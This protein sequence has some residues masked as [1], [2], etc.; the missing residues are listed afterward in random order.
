MTSSNF[1]LLL[2]LIFRGEP[3]RDVSERFSPNR[4][5]SRKSARFYRLALAF[6]FLLA[7]PFAAFSSD[8]DAAFEPNFANETVLEATDI[9]ETDTIAS[10]PTF[11]EIS[12]ANT[13]SSDENEFETIVVS[14]DSLE[15]ASPNGDANGSET[16]PN[17]VRFLQKLRPFKRAQTNRV[18]GARVFDFDAPEPPEVEKI[19]PP[20]LTKENPDLPPLD[21]DGRLDSNGQF[22]TRAELDALRDETKS[23]VWSKGDLRITPY[24]FLNLSVSSDTQRAVPG[25]FILYPQSADV[26]DSADFSVD[27]RT[28]RLGFK[29]DGPRVDALSADVRGC[30]EFDFQ[31]VANGS[32][33]KGGVQLRRAYVELVDA[34][35]ERRLLAGQDWEII[36]PLAPQMLNYLPAGYA[37]NLQYRRPQLRFEQ[38]A[39]FGPNLRFLG[40]IAICD[41]VLSDYASTTGVS[42]TSAAWPVIEARG[43]VALFKEA[44]GGLPITLGV[45]GHIGEQNYSFSP[46]AGTF[47]QTKERVAIKTWSTNFDVDVPLTKALRLQ[48]EYFIGSNLSTFCGGINQGVDLYRRDGIAA[49]GGW[50]ALH[51]DWTPKFSTNVGYGVDKPN[52]NDLVG[53]SMPSN[54]LATSRTRNET[55][56]ANLM[57]NWNQNLL[58]GIEFSYWNA[59]YRRADVTGAQPIF[60]EMAPGETFRTEFAVRLSF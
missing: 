11:Y 6:G 50:I 59:E 2:R 54:G 60:H 52:E 39:T 23:L 28:S 25:E 16:E 37:G 4:E 51:T 9:S 26:D 44:R 43:S 38:G 58:T 42:P 17:G 40:Q 7:S 21:Y 15:A 24:G 33:N 10:V 14:S 57:Y 12:S 30:F 27:A 36:S 19:G 35:R 20:A 1:S 41:D 45:S 56:F 5:N 29:I 49:S 32:K 46:I 47:V 3:R 31:G 8:D 48:G 18:F 22:A 55:Y 53:T 13:E 34:E